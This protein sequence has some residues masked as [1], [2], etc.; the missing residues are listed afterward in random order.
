MCGSLIAVLSGLCFHLKYC[1]VL[2]FSYI[3]KARSQNACYPPSYRENSHLNR[4][5][6]NIK[7]YAVLMFSSSVALNS[8]GN[9]PLLA[10]WN[11]LFH[12][13]PK[14]VLISSPIL[15]IAKT[16]LK[17]K[18][19]HSYMCSNKYPGFAFSILLYGISWCSRNGLSCHKFTRTFFARMF[20]FSNISTNNVF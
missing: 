17:V 2:K 4:K 8:L 3:T 20:L 19:M 13:S 15:V 14:H 16:T 5:L 9:P 18:R 12:G 7:N 11:C 1:W 10:W 6:G